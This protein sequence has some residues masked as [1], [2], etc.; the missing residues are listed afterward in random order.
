MQ[1]DDIAKTALSSWKNLPR[2]TRGPR[3]QQIQSLD[4]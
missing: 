3:P 2:R 1:Q 4:L